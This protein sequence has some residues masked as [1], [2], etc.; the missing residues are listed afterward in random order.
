MRK[1]ILR[2]VLAVAIC[3]VT[4][5]GA[6]GL[7][8]PYFTDMTGGISV[9]AAVSGSFEYTVSA[10]GKYVT[11]DKCRSSS[12]A[13]TIPD[14][15]AGKPVTRI[16]NEAFTSCTRVQTISIPSSVE[17]IGSMAFS[18][19]QKLTALKLP[20][21]L[22]QIGTYAFGYCTSL[23]EVTIP[24]SV[25]NIGYGAFCE[26]YSL[27][28][29]K[30]ESGNQKYV[31]V[32]GV[33]FT[34]AKDRLVQCPGAKSGK[35][36]VPSGVSY[37]SEY[38][39]QGCQ[40]ITE[41]ILPSGVSSIEMSAFCEC[42]SLRK[43]YIP[44]TVKNISSSAFEFCEDVTI[45]GDKDTYAHKYA[46]R[47]GMKFVVSE[48]S[49]ESTIS[50]SVIVLGG[51]VT[52]NAKAAG[53]TGT[54]T[55]AVL[56]KKKA[57]TKWTVK[58]NYTTNAEIVVKPAKATDYDICVKVKDGKGDIVKKFFTVKVNAKLANNSTLSASSVKH[59]STFTAYA[60]ASGGMGG[61]TYAV[62]YKKKA[63]TKW[64]V[65]QNYST[66]AKIAVKPAKVTDYD[67]CVK[68]KDSA[69]TIAKKYFTVTVTA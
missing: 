64:T 22:K 21:S 58:Q 62:L 61:Y 68:V 19:L 10:D 54:Y 55:Y 27:T 39:F 24:V 34:K 8:V 60:K 45:Y 5:T 36:T 49:N 18:G 52:V 11:I 50:E 13:I 23:K 51:T 66:N 43:I 3:A 56:Y 26:C 46:L 59:G 6:G 65:K 28:A 1:K 42:T 53:G 48:L 25:T 40:N 12:T 69:G 41:V 33:L 30:V 7:G 2:R 29:L 16:G 15:I 31:S 17:Y 20:S 9:N 57:D 32:S 38:A 63:D 37:I 14:T 44:A 35:Y 67:V 47:K 4:V